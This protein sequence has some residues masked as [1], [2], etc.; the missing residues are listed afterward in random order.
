MRKAIVLGLVGLVVAVMAA[1]LIVPSVIDW[2]AYK[3]RIVAHLKSAL[4]RDVS[5]EG[6]L[7]MALLPRP[8]LSAE[9]VR[10]A[11][12]G[13]AAVPD[14]VTV[15]ALRLRLAFGPLLSGDIRV[16]TLVLEEPVVSLEEL[17]QGRRNW[18]FGKAAEVPAGRSESDA[19]AAAPPPSDDGAVDIR[20][21][22]LIV[23]NGALVYRGPDGRVEEIRKLDLELSA[24]SL[25]GPFKGQGGLAW[26]NVPTSFQFSLGRLETDRPTAA[27]AVLALPGT[28]AEGRL[29]GQ[30]SLGETPGFE[31]RLS[32]SG[33]DLAALAAAL[34]GISAPG[35]S[36]PFSLE[37]VI[38]A[39]ADQV[40][41]GEA[42]IALG[43]T[44]A[45]G[46]L[47]AELGEQPRVDATIAFGRLDLDTLLGAAGAATPAS[48]RAAAPAA[49]RPAPPVEEAAFAL[50]ADISGSID[51][52]AEIVVWRK[53]LIRQA[54]LGATL[55]GGAITIDRAGALLPGGSD[56]SIYGTLA[57]NEGLPVFDG[58]FDAA[59]DN[60]RGVAEWLGVDLGAVPADRLRKLLASGKLRATPKNIMLSGLDVRLDTTRASGALTVRPG[61]RL[62]VGANLEV[63]SI[64]LDAYRPAPEP[65]AAAAAG[66]PAG[67][68]AS[69]DAAESGPAAADLQALAGFDANVKVKVGQLV[70]NEVALKDLVLDGAL[71]NGVL[72][73]REAAVGEL[74]GASGRL[75]GVVETAP[76]PRVRKLQYALRTKEPEKVA[77]LFGLDLPVP[78]ERLRSLAMTGMLD[79]GLDGLSVDTRTEAGGAT[80]VVKGEVRDP[81]GKL[82]YDLTAEMSHSSFAEFVR[83][84]A[85]DYR[86]QAAAGGFALT[87][88]LTGDAA[89]VA[90]GDLR[91]KAGPANL[92]GEGKLEFAGPPRLTASLNGG[93]IP[94]DAFLP[95]DRTAAAPPSMIVP[96]AAG[97]PPRPQPG[98]VQRWSDEPFD[99]AWLNAFAAHLQVNLQAATYGEWRVGQPVLALAVTDGKALLERF[100]GT[101]FGGSLAATGGI[102]GDG[103][104]SLEATLSNVSMR[105][106]LIGAAGLDVADGLLAAD[107]DLTSKGRS[108]FELVSRL[109]GNGRLEVRDGVVRGFD[110]DAVSRQLGDI[111]N[112][113]SLLGLVQAGMS[114]GAT[115][116]SSLTGSFQAE[117]GVIASRDLAL[118]AEGGTG[119]GT[120]TVNLPAYS[121]DARAEFGLTAHPEAPPFVFVLKGPLDQPRRIVEVNELQTWLVA[122][123]IGQLLGKKGGDVGR[124]L[125]GILSGGQPQ[126]RPSPQRPAS[127][128]AIEQPR[129]EPA[130]LRPEQLIEGIIRQLGR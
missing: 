67:R 122:R 115:R 125:E 55:A 28:G 107:L 80:L 128:D 18:E 95:A 58:G 89:A 114:G 69:G 25:Q 112:A 116:F 54:R 30:L 108:M 109:G 91:L 126:A 92:A 121:I 17:P 1:V 11:N 4:G 85:P 46:R 42:R 64:N 124:A 35:I 118:A 96:V 127:P 13:E 63:D 103:G 73:L 129:Q 82:A 98:A 40:S 43:E 77:R 105:D 87:A 52:S 27:N 31:G 76:A 119:R 26:R 38:S 36:A 99:L 117:N 93:E 86:P 56:L 53:G 100:T 111:R 14:M 19:Q 39:V 8:A 61:G 3:P 10:I 50:P 79:G 101:V 68:P 106:A 22:S 20:L 41:L 47:T 62:A 48:E 23:E 57:A 32:L 78:P 60:L 49:E 66:G 16:E 9:R 21:D 81:L 33:K 120:A 97:T 71:V 94:L 72:T 12:I 37:G 7:S 6:D 65:A 74:G 2:N 113:G 102:A 59:A 83:I 84:V 88:R 5:I 29:S 130:P 90:L 123:G 75:T 51:A 104:A 15:K 34:P 110:L 44:T 70:V 45:T 24:G